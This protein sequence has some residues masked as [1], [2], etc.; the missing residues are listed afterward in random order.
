MNAPQ[1]QDIAQ[2]Q[3]QV[4]QLTALVGQL[5][6]MQ[7]QGQP[8]APIQPAAYQPYAAR[9]NFEVPRNEPA[10][11]AAELQFRAE[12]ERKCRELSEMQEQLASVQW[13]YQSLL[14]AK[15]QQIVQQRDARMRRQLGETEEAGDKPVVAAA[16][17][18]PR[19]GVV[20]T[21]RLASSARP[22]VSSPN[23]TEEVARPP[24]RLR[25]Q[26]NNTVASAMSQDSAPRRAPSTTQQVEFSEV[27][28]EPVT[29][30]DEPVTS[31]E[32]AGPSESRLG[33]WFKR[34]K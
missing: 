25:G 13:E 28:A 16:A 12:Y 5:A 29:K 32:E 22:A 27:A 9:A 7:Q 33:R 15:Q 4:N 20:G 8:A 2:L 24:L 34:S 1:H 31:T 14:E 17:G 6:A 30:S 18:M 10:P 19:A 11:S 3:Q 23:R 26:Q 21:E